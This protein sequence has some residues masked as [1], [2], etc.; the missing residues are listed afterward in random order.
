MRDL[1]F[2]SRIPYTSINRSMR[3]I[4]RKPHRD[5]A[6]ESRSLAHD[7]IAVLR[8]KFRKQFTFMKKCGKI[9][10]VFYKGSFI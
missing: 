2:S 4:A 10:G 6:G 8:P 7:F 5:L 9:D 3:K 1:I